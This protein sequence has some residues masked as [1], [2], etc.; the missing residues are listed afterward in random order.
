MTSQNF[1][2]EPALPSDHAATEQLLDLAFGLSRQTKTSYRLREGNKAIAG[3]SFAVRDAG[4]GLVGAIS[5]WPL[6]IGRNGT[7]AL[8]LGPLAVHPERQNLG[9]GLA[10]MRTGLDK[11]RAL[12]HRLV[13]LVGDQPYYARVGFK[14]VPP[15]L[16]ELPGPVDPARLLYLELAAGELDLA[17]GLVLPPHRHAELS[18]AFA[19]PHRRKAEQQETQAQQ[20]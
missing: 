3:L 17:E 5:F 20:G 15:G 10:L 11:A 4:L 1:A 2:V 9:I 12:G 14:P 18:A 19:I 13:I 16:I 6:K 8:L 7:D